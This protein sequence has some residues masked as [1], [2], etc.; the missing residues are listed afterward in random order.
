MVPLFKTLINH[1]HSLLTTINYELHII[2]RYSSLLTM[3]YDHQPVILLRLGPLSPRR[4]GSPGTQVLRSLD[5]PNII[6]LFE[7]GEDVEKQQ[8]HLLMVRRGVQPVT[9]EGVEQSWCTFLNDF[10]L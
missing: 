10:L 1:Y 2:N 6:R 4:S 9:A 5:H 3:T 7:Y 8:I